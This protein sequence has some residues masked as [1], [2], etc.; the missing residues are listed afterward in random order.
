LRAGIRKPTNNGE[1][2]FGHIRRAES[3]GANVHRV[4]RFVEKP[5][6]ATAQGYLA[7]G[8]YYWNLLA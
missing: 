7:D 5:D 3:M 6:L 2:G 8:S 1:Q 4:E